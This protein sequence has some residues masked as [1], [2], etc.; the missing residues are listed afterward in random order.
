LIHVS[1]CLEVSQN[2]NVLA[3]KFV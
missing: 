2:W 1:Y 3:G